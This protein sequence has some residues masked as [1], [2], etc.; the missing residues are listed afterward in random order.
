M[1]LRNRIKIAAN[2]LRG[3]IIDSQRVITKGIDVGTGTVGIFGG[4]NESKENKFEQV[5]IADLENEDLDELIVKLVKSDP[6]LDQAADFFTTLVTQGHE[7][8]SESSRGE[9]AIEE[10]NGILEESKTSLDVIV[11]HCASSLIIRGDICAETEFD[12]SNHPKNFW[13]EDPIHVEWKYLREEGGA[14]WALG[15]MVNGRWQEI[16][17]PNV[18][19]LAGNPL[20]GERASRSPLQTALF[21]AV[22]QTAMI[23]SLQSILDVHAWAQTLFKVKKL[24]L[25][26]LENEGGDIDDVNETIQE[27]M[28]LIATLAKKKPNQ[29]MGMTDDIEPVELSGGGEKYGFTRDIGLLYDKRIS[30]G[31]KLASTIGGPAE[32]ADYSTR[33]QGLFYSSYLQSGQ[34]NIKTP[35]EWGYRR[36][37]RSIGV[38]SDPIYTTK[39][40]NVESRM[41]EAKAFQEIMTG[42]N[43]ATQAGMPLPLAIEFF[44]EEA[45]QTFSGELKAKIEEQYVAPVNAE[46]NNEEPEDEDDE[47]ETQDNSYIRTA[48]QAFLARKHRRKFQRRSR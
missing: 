4:L 21:P 5:T 9:R 34:A 40:V 38:P 28:D 45:G 2:I 15:Q 11:K 1:N 7:V 23:R 25:I 42:I 29:V 3:R 35:I 44:E 36:F 19:Y 39:S 41:I 14:R 10:I 48:G 47:Q 13:I 24:E 43:L 18:Y 8:T 32:R 17:S 26:K 27:A 31:T 20:V 16:S 22:S 12:E 33:Q 46:P 37:M 6:A 30:A